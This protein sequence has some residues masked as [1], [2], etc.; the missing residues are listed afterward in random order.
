MINPP[1][2]CTGSACPR[3]RTCSSTPRPVA[4][5]INSP[6]LSTVT[7]FDSN[8]DVLATRSASGGSGADS[9][10][11]ELVQGLGPGT[12]F[13]GISAA[14]NVPGQGGGYDPVSGKP[15]IA[16]VNDPAGPF[17]LE[18]SATPARGSTTLV[19]FN[20]D[21]A[22]S[23]EP[24]PTGLDLTFSG[25]VNVTGLS[26]PD[27]QETALTVVDTSGRTWPISAIS[28]QSAQDRLSFLFNEALPP[29]AT[30]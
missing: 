4:R 29:G 14:G 22:D 19:N 24:S 18:L 28:Y 12:Y 11:P 1:S 25:P 2:R 8:G 6:L 26:V 16:G 20:L 10:D 27:R 7:L 13:L 30:R 15:G 21:Y 9:T 3:A 17:V 5:A 23:L